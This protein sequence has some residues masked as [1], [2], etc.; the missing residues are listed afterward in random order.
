MLRMYLICITSE[1]HKWAGNAF[2]VRS[3]KT[4]GTPNLGCHLILIKTFSLSRYVHVSLRTYLSPWNLL[5]SLSDIWVAFWIC[6]ATSKMRIATANT[7][8][9]TVHTASIYDQKRAWYVNLTKQAFT[10]MIR[11]ACSR[12][13]VVVDW[14][15]YVATCRYR[16]Y[17]RY[18]ARLSRLYNNC[19]SKRLGGK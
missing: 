1:V 3:S 8:H 7:M 2:N 12:A 10:S 17:E 6:S 9:T 16:T 11:R 15:G 4:F 19:V 5:M 14:S 13:S 18:L